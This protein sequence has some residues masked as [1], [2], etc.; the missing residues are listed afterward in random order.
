LLV[1]AGGK[2][3]KIAALVPSRRTHRHRYYGV[4]APNASSRAAVTTLA[5]GAV[6]APSSPPAAAAEAKEDP[7]HRAVSRWL[8]AMLLA[9]VDEASPLTC[10]ICHA[11]MR[12]VAII[13]EACT[14]RKIR[15]HI[16]ESPQPAGH[17]YGRRQRLSNRR[18]TTRKGTSSP[19]PNR[20]SH[21]ISAAPGD[22]QLILVLDTPVRLTQRTPGLQR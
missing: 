17:R 10:P 3:D 18:A 14:V 9:R 2:F 11:E 22:E 8:W 1:L 19:R 4:L 21:S 6:R 16:G 20:R 12:I 15:D 5:A 7:R 13:N